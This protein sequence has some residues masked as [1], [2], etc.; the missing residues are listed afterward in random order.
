MDKE[1]VG[2]EKAVHMSWIYQSL[3]CRVPFM[4]PDI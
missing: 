4:V 2:E 1:D 3:N